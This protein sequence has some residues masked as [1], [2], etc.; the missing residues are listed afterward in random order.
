MTST[1][2]TLQT[3]IAQGLRLHHAGDLP[4]AAR[5]YEAALERDPADADASCLLGMVHHAAGRPDQAIEWIQRAV[6]ARPEVP[7]YHASLGLTYQSMERYVDAADAFARVL[8]LSPTDTAAHVN[9]GVA[10]RTLGDR[11]AALA[12][13]RRAVELDPRLAQARTNLGEILLELGRP[14]E[15]L[16][17]CQ[18]AVALEPG[19]VEAHL[20][21][22][23]VLLAMGRIPE[24]TA[25][26]FQAYR[27]DENRARTAAALGL[28]AVRR[29]VVNEALG[30]FRRAV[31]LEPGSVE[32]LRYLAEAAG[33]LKVYGEVRSCCERILAI[34]PDQAVAHNAL[35]WVLQG[36]N[37]YDEARAHF[38]A[39]IRLEPRFATAH[40]NLGVLHEDLGDLDR[41]E[42]LYRR[43]LELDPN[44][45]TALAR[46]G[47]LLRGSLPDSD[48]DGI[49]R[50]LA[51]P[52]LLTRDRA[53]LLFA[54]ALVRDQRGECRGAAACL[55]EANALALAELAAQG[56][57]YDSEANRRL[58]EGIIAAFTPGLFV[59]LAGA[60]LETSRPVFIIGLPRSG[61][62]LL[63]QVLASH[64]EVHGA[65]EVGFSRESLEALPEL[66]GR[67]G[68]P[69]DSVPL[70]DPP[71]L[72]ELARRHERRL[73]ALDGGKARRTIS[74]MPEDYF[75]LGL[76]ALMFPRAV[77]IH[78][79]RDIRD[80]ALS[81]W[82]TN[83]TEVPW[84][85]HQE[86]IASRIG[87]YHRLMD[88]WRAVLPPTFAFHEVDYEAAVD[89]L[90][91]VARRLL[92]A[93]GLEWN[94]SCLE[95]HRTRRPVKTASQVQ[96]RKPI[97]RGSVGRWRLYQDELADLFA[98]VGA[99]SGGH[100]LQR[101]GA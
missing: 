79:R 60:G 17:H 25:S 87:G 24:A 35:A 45:P 48:L 63:E 65:G 42:A 95:F 6:A 75:Y 54:L 22:G 101:S 51:D 57:S 11:D 97:Y 69:L 30:W 99:G 61:T 38:E 27:L 98:K 14:D 10:V 21:L 85:N 70:L 5:L 18:A 43:T 66:T 34:D 1:S 55:E 19:L 12:H 92:S 49:S 36:S 94:P 50:R 67:G 72:Q 26:Y 96:V 59:R 32:Y 53:N 28:A 47:E 9:R 89:D 100:E 13:F 23:N 56:R 15:A 86:H 80:V 33:V 31:A 83:F 16:P 62:T 44:H 41:A 46:L 78:C 3:E 20:H 29:G 74:K 40:F 91:G 39:A 73:L 8:E 88:H 76:I 81:C 64:P 84:A 7:A 77:V 4:G 68:D 37:R 58:V 93:M 52:D 71:S 82:L 90:E 2:P